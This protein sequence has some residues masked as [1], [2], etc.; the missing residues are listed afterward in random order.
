MISV[1]PGKSCRQAAKASGGISLEFAQYIGDCA[2]GGKVEQQVDVGGAADR[3]DMYL[4]ARRNSA[5][6]VPG[7]GRIGDDR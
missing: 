4:G 3:T 1:L 7:F 5:E 6:N 2:G